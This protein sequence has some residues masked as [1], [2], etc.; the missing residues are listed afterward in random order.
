MKAAMIIQPKLI[1]LSPASAKEWDLLLRNYSGE[2]VKLTDSKQLEELA[3]S[4]PQLILLDHSLVDESAVQRLSK[5]GHQV[6]LVAEQWTPAQQKQLLAA[7]AA[8][9]LT[10]PLAPELLRQRINDQW[11]LLRIAQGMLDPLTQLPNRRHL[12]Q[13]LQRQLPKDTQAAK[14]FA[15]MFIDLEHFRKVNDVH[16]HLF[17][18][19][20]LRS[21]AEQMRA[22]IPEEC[23]LCRYGGDEF[24]VVLPPEDS[25]ELQARQLAIRLISLL[26]QPLLVE[27]RQ[28][29]LGASV[30]IS[31][32]PEHGESAEI[33]LKHADIAMFQAKSRGTGD[34]M[35]YSQ[36]MAEGDNYRQMLEQRLPKAMQQGQLVMYYQPVFD[37]VTSQVVCAEA[38]LRWEEPELG[39]IPPGDFLS[40]AE[41]AGL[42][43]SLGKY[44]LSEVCQTLA[45]W[46]RAGVQ[47]SIS[48]N[49][50]TFQ[51]DGLDFLN[52]VH[53]VT[54]QHDIELSQL[55]FEITEP[56][57][58]NATERKLEQLIA[59]QR[60][61]A[62]II[63]DDFGSG[64]SDL[65]TLVR[66]PLAEVKID[67][68]FVSKAVESAET[69]LLVKG[70]IQFAHTL[71]MQVAAEGIESAQQR[72]LLLYLGCE[73]G[74]GFEFAHPMPGELFIS[75]FT[76]DNAL[77]LQ[78]VPK[79]SN[80]IE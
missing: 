75:W 67:R 43:D 6:L 20:L 32:Y 10:L 23:L 80:A 57:L 52:R 11:R 21:V 48:I 33:L 78:T 40:V 25:P 44:I 69:R 72:D 77:T 46:Q 58:F 54:E 24:V 50:S 35:L 16:G 62:K 60:A 37:L 36:F 56:M 68:Q 34:V 12:M 79:V 41:S 59:L 7:G 2:I 73:L 61:G 13:K 51:L 47:L 63:L 55:Q 74:Q 15:L 26:E 76:Q 4:Q 14:P 22:E 1:T 42:A 70:L 9:L 53:E 19:A 18:D 64:R 27:G 71:G 30:G 3:K 8:D 49:L 45:A 17:G 65:S 38:L 39:L 66:I 31:L 29:T 5:V 28:V